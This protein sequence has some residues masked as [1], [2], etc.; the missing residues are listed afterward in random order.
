MEF[1]ARCIWHTLGA[2][3]L[4]GNLFQV[5]QKGPAFSILNLDGARLH[6]S[7]DPEMGKNWAGYEFADPIV[8]TLQQVQTRE[9]RA[10]ERIC[11]V[12]VLSTSKNGEA[13]KAER[14]GESSALVGSGSSRALVGVRSGDGEIVPGLVTD[15]RIYWIGADRI[16]LGDVSSLSLSGAPVMSAS[17]RV[18]IEI[19]PSGEAIVVAEAPT[20]ISVAADGPMKTIQLPAGRHQLSGL[21]VP[22]RFEF[23]LPKPSPATAQSEVVPTGPKKLSAAGTPAPGAKILSLAADASGVYVGRA[24]G[25][26]DALCGNTLWTFDAGDPVSAVW[27]GRLAKNDPPRIAVGTAKG[28]IYLLDESGG[29]IW[30]RQIPYYKVVPLVDYF[31][32][33]GLAGYDNKALIVGSDNWHHYAYDSAGNQLWSYE[34]VHGSTTGM[35]IDLDG[36]GKQE[37]IVGTEYNQIHALNPDG[38]ARWHI[39]RVGGPRINA[40]VPS[41]GKP[42]VVFGGAEGTVYAYGV[43]GKQQW[44][45][46]TG[47]E[48]TCMASGGGQILAGSRSFSLTALDNAGR[49]LWRVDVGEPILCMTLVDLNDDLDSGGSVEIAVGTEDGHVIALNFKGDILATWSTQ[50]PVRKLAAFAGSLA[51]AC[52]DGR[53]VL[54]KME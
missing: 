41:T 53:A 8:H 31:I 13:P 16:A 18:S 32:S 11:F 39:T 2:P 14:A 23:D 37:V 46:S 36:D 42:G 24:D 7:D 3:K 40:I 48:I 28:K 50:G 44:S 26:L 15:A 1:S 27:L 25:K 35:A 54:L 20:R 9:L 43:D 12:N 30:D 17:N 47:D 45:Y 51:V 38:T 52:E 29:R 49:R 5:S 21:N 34:S 22:S 10:G 33:A 4:T 19:D 6:C